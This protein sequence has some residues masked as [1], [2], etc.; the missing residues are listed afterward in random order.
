MI[1]TQYTTLSLFASSMRTHVSLSTKE[2]LELIAELAKSVTL[3][4]RN[5]GSGMFIPAIHKQIS[6][7][8]PTKDFPSGL[9][10]YVSEE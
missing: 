6:Q 5:G 4:D 1:I 3:V 7:G 9:A 8:K 10:F 2:A